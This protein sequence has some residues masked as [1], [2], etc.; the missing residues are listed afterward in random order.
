MINLILPALAP[1]IND[2][3]ALNIKGQGT[4]L[5]MKK[6]QSLMQQWVQ[7]SDWLEEQ[8]TI[9]NTPKGFKS[10]LLY[11][12]PNHDMAVNLVAWQ[13]GC[14]IAPHDH[15]TWA[16]VG[17]ISGI[18]KNYFWTRLDDGSIPGYADLKRQEPPVICH[19]GEVIAIKADQIH[20][21]V[22]IADVIA[23]SLHVYGRNL[24]YTNRCKYD[25]SK[26][27][28]EDFVIDFNH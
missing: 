13:P 1:F 27:T 19:P 22:N 3:K 23:I 17:C 16:V 2:L 28:V 9:V 20:S 21:V 8:F 5:D 4:F 11:E 12:E 7:K 25:P 15:C 14:E 24:N 18:E 10:W 26:H 6:V